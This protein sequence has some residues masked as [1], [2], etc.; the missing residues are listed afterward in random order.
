MR[1]IAFYKKLTL[2]CIVLLYVLSVHAASTPED[3]VRQFGNTLSEWCRSDKIE[4]RIDIE[5]LCSGKKSCRV[6]DKVLADYLYRKG[7]SDHETFCLDSY[8]NMFED[9]IS[10]GITFNMTNIKTEA[11]DNYPDGQVLTFITANIILSGA[12]NY[13]VKNLFLV[14][15][16]KISG[17]Y[18]H[19][20][21]RSFSH[22]NGSLIKA[23]RENNY[24][25][26]YEFIN[27]FAVVADVNRRYGVIDVKGNVVV[28]CK[29][30]AMD[31]VGDSFAYGF[32]WKTDDK[33]L[34]V[35]DLRRG[36]KETPFNQVITWIV[37]REKIPTTFSDGYAVVQ[38]KEGKYGFLQESDLTYENVSFEYDDASRFC[39]GYAVVRKNGIAMVINK[40]FKPVLKE[41]SNYH[42]IID[43]PYEGT[44]TVKNN[45]NKFGRMDLQGK[46]IVPCSYDNAE[47]FVSGLCRVEIGDFTDRKIGFMNKKGNMVIPVGS[48]SGCWSVGFEDG[49][50][51]ATKEITLEYYKDGKVIKSKELR[52]TL[53]GI[54]G[55][56]LPG[57]NWDYSGVRRF[58]DG[59]ARFEQNGKS[60]YLNRKGE[61]AILPTYE[62]ALFF[63]DGYACVGQKVDGK[64]KYGCINTDGVLII[65]Y[66][67]DNPFFFD[68]GVATIVQDGKAGLIDA[69]GNTSF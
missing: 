12:L 25:N 51:E 39:D 61:V 16:G 55:N 10:D 28:P 23:L 47:G 66:I 19:S 13:E 65:P 18:H 1:D 11:Q 35:Y 60:G 41:K 57:F 46:M 54:D 59:L 32:N 53:L 27:G 30:D 44:I 36:G 68:N 24:T 49:Y 14:R 4:S 56:P 45:N 38:N 8:L 52:G 42:F 62:F 26:I 64:M 2:S 50:I 48:L 3:V 34:C 67:Y 7:Q 15:D 20:T 17:I 58:C 63:K 22:L 9:L 40:E 69:Y 29:W 33:S 6:E 21:A 31:Y 43:R 5:K 37:G